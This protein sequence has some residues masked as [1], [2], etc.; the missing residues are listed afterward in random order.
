ML[1]AALVLPLLLGLAIAV[2]SC[3]DDDDGGSTPT[4]TTAVAPSATPTSGE[5]GP[6]PGATSEPTAAVTTAAQLCGSEMSLEG[7]PLAAG[8]EFALNSLERWQFCNGGAAAG[9]SEKWLFHTADGGESW[10]LISRTTLG[11]PPPVAGVGELP[12]GNGVVQIL[13]ADAQDGFLGLNSPG[14]NLW[15]S[16]DGGVSW[17]A[18]DVVPPAEAVQSISLSGGTVT[19]V[20]TAGTWTTDDNGATW[21]RV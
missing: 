4:T 15:Q 17:S 10:E 13:F 12:N 6:T 3:G 16:T 9:S 14:E 21:S 11:N 20:T 1:R 7:Q 8:K 5:A 19:V 18:V 2:A